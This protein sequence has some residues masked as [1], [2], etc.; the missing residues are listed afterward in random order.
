MWE[1]E[2][3]G[4]FVGMLVRF[5]DRVGEGYFVFDGGS[6]MLLVTMLSD[7]VSGAGAG[8]VGAG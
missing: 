4:K 6:G 8:F 3:E 7:V 5:F 2:L 1:V